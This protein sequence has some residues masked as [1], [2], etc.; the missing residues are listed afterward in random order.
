M[1]RTMRAKLKMYI[2][3]D[4]A[5]AGTLLKPH[6]G[7]NPDAFHGPRSQPKDV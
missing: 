1:V 7:K 4:G 5:K 3:R 6:G 2:I